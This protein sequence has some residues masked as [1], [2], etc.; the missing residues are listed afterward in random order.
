VTAIREETRGPARIV[1]VARTAKKNALDSA[2]AEELS[3]ALARASADPTVRGVVLAA[4]GDVFL[5]G[6]DLGELAGWLDAAGGAEKVLAIGRR[7][8]VVD[9]MEVPLVAAIGGDV[10]GG[11][12]EVVL[13]CDDAIVEEHARL[14]FRHARMGLS[15]AWGGTARLVERVGR[16]RAS[17]LLF[18]A[19][20][21][22]AARAVQI[23]LAS[24]VVARGTAVEVAVQ[25]IEALA[26]ADRAVIAAQRRLLRETARETAASTREHEA[27]TFRR[28]WAGP[29]HR[30][31]MSAFAGR[32]IG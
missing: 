30:A 4:D 5:S 17:Q 22:D 1:V 16:M 27:E 28:L 8:D 25:R 6:G 19:E 24:E 32:R 10:H 11:G 7:L 31:A 3:A 15:P 18:G 12:C 14:V 29:A 9:T 2:T 20:P 23:G 13:A 21:V 26:R